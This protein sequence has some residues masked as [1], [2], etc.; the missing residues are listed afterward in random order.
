MSQNVFIVERFFSSLFRWKPK[1]LKV[2]LEKERH[3]T[4][5]YA[6]MCSAIS[7]ISRMMTTLM[8][9]KVE[10]GKKTDNMTSFWTYI[11]IVKVVKKHFSAKTLTRN[12]HIR[13]RWCHYLNDSHSVYVRIFVNLCGRF[14]FLFVVAGLTSF[15]TIFWFEQFNL[16][17]LNP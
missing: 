17:R 14:A 12:S 5:T 6:F 3:F 2:K 15:L 10:W 13:L 9:I 7:A 1:P 16:K 8:E 11:N 4:R